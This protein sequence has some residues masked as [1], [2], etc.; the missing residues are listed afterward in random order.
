M[1]RAIECLRAY[2]LGLRPIAARDLSMFSRFGTVLTMPSGF[3]FV[4]EAVV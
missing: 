3:L 4:A 1:L 2:P